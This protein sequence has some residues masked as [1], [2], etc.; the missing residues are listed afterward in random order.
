[1]ITAA[2]T[3]SSSP[4]PKLGLPA[5]ERA[6][7]IMPARDAVKPEMTKA[8]I[9]VRSVLTPENRA[10]IGLP[11]VAKILRPN[12]IW[13]SRCRQD[14]CPHDRRLYADKRAVPEYRRKGIVK[15]WDGP[16]IGDR[17][18]QA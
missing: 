18:R 2:I 15:N 17:Q 3:S 5:V 9:F 12:G 8:A 1:M 6:A 13:C 14:D 7:S 11:P 10:A 16:R 4:A